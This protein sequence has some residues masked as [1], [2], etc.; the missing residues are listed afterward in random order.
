M[1]SEKMEA[2]FYSFMKKPQNTAD[3]TTGPGGLQ[4][5]GYRM[6]VT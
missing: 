4:D 3:F 2:L 5:D 1:C 6:M